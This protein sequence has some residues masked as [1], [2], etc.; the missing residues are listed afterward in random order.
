MKK[1]IITAFVFSCSLSVL[2]QQKKRLEKKKF[3]TAQAITYWYNSPV[4]IGVAHP[5]VS[6][7]TWVAY[8]GAWEFH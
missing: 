6:A 1:I 3:L 2:A 5:T 8:P 4:T 7:A